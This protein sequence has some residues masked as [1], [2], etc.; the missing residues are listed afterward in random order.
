VS[1]A[2]HEC[3]AGYT[4]DS[5]WG[6]T[7]EHEHPWTHGLDYYVLATFGLLP[8]QEDIS[9]RLGARRD[10][11]AFPARE[12]AMLGLPALMFRTFASR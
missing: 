2:R 3:G 12:I 4:F 11:G 9:P 1:N 7:R 8:Q 6:Y 10:C 5:W